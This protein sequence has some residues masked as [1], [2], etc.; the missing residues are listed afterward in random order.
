MGF[1]DKSWNEEGF[2]VYVDGSRYLSLGPN[3]TVFSLT[4]GCEV[5][6]VRVTAHNAAGES[7]ATNTITIEGTCPLATVPNV[8]GLHYRDALAALEDAGFFNVRYA[9]GEDEPIHQDVLG[10]GCEAPDYDDCAGERW[11]VDTEI[12]VLVGCWQEFPWTCDWP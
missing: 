11:P 7:A 3:E 2:Y 6:D 9:I 8:Y 12:F 1:V 10:Y 4:P 5:W